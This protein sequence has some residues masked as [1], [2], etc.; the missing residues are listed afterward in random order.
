MPRGCRAKLSCAAVADA[1]IVFAQLHNTK[2]AWW[3]H[4]SPHFRCFLPP[5]LPRRLRRLK[6]AAP[7]GSSLSSVVLS[8]QLL[9]FSSS[10]AWLA[11]SPA[12]SP[13]SIL[14]THSFELLVLS[15]AS[16][17]ASVTSS[18]SSASPA[19]ASL[20]LASSALAS[21][22]STPHGIDKRLA[23]ALELVASVITWAYLSGLL[24]EIDQRFSMSWRAVSGMGQSSANAQA[25]M[26]P[27]STNRDCS[28]FFNSC[29]SERME[30]AQAGSF[31]AFKEAMLRRS[32][33]AVRFNTLVC[34][35]R[36]CTRSFILWCR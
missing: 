26:L 13:E 23:K 36:L 28:R 31:R 9:L 29:R 34:S 11:S 4:S 1:D 30:V 25:C 8:S 5:R 32:T 16:T 14:A 6:G 3:R 2:A 27:S 10:D 7:L 19:L 21:S 24:P 20:A 22:S 17:P 12:L 35:S 18:L 15:S 33:A